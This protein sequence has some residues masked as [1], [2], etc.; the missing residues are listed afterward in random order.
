MYIV[1]CRYNDFFT[2][3]AQSLPTRKKTESLSNDFYN[4]RNNQYTYCYIISTGAYYSKH[5]F[6]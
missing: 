2:I 1:F 3:A 4:I 6:K 5:A